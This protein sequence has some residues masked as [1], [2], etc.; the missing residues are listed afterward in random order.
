[1]GY[2]NVGQ[3]R[4]PAPSQFALTANEGLALMYGKEMQHFLLQGP[5]VVFHRKACM[6][7]FLLI[8]IQYF[9]CTV[10]L[11]QMSL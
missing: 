10:E 11:H 6:L 7:F 4:P 2:E 9:L 3:P 1:M 5:C 8:F